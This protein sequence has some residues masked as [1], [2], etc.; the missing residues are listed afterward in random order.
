MRPAI[1]PAISWFLV[2][3]LNH[4]NS[5]YASFNSSNSAN[6]P[7]LRTHREDTIGQGG[8]KSQT[9]RA[10][11]LP[12]H[13]PPDTHSTNLVSRVKGLGELWVPRCH[14]FRCHHFRS[15]K[16]NKGNQVNSSCALG[17]HGANHKA[18]LHNGQRPKQEGAALG[19]K[20]DSP[21]QRKGERNTNTAQQRPGTQVFFVVSISQGKTPQQSATH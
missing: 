14:H 3:F 13:P 19:G 15:L 8:Q 5:K 16:A 18:N 6:I 7:S 9:C 10:R 21:S 2:G 4:W 12:S 20:I 17:P 11:E 1:E